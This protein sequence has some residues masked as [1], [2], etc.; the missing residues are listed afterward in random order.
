MRGIL[1]ALK[2]IGRWPQRLGNEGVSLIEL[3]AAV[4]VLA[5]LVGVAAPSFLTMMGRS[6][7]DAA[8]RQLLSDVR[9]ARSMAIGQ[10]GWEY[11]VLGFN[12]NAPSPFA[13][14]YRILGR[15]PGQPWPADTVAPFPQNATQMAGPW[16]NMNAEYSGAM[17]NP[18]DGTS[19][20]WVTFNARGVRIDIDNSFNPS[21]VITDGGTMQRRVS[22]SLPGVVTIQ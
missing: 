18:A 4:A 12:A 13:N 17:I 20:F 1:Q 3:V 10:V 22:V 19:R 11:K 9:L 14:Q 21:L 6:Q 15:G 16:V 5:L 7:V 8:S 2:A